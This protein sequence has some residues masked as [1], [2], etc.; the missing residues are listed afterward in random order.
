MSKVP[1]AQVERLGRLDAASVTVDRANK[2]PF[3]PLRPLATPRPAEAAG[4]SP[5]RHI[6]IA[7]T[8]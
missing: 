2:D 4:L 8:T 1:G 6:K 3:V 7:E 5:A